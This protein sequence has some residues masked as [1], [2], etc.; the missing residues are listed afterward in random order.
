LVGKEIGSF[1]TEGTVPKYRVIEK[2][3]RDLK[4]L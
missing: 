2:D 3:E 1:C 4:P